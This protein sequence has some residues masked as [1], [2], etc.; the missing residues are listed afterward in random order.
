MEKESK[1]KA[2]KRL[3]IVIKL[4]E[5]QKYRRKEKKR[6]EKSQKTSLIMLLLRHEFD[7]G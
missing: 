5:C 6:K 3:T 7:C 1:M 2:S 4:G